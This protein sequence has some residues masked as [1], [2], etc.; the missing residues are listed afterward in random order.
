[1]TARTWRRAAGLVTT[2]LLFTPAI[3]AR[4]AAPPTVSTDPAT[5][6]VLAA[7]PHHPAKPA[8]TLI[9]TDWWLTGI[10]GDGASRDPVL[11]YTIDMIGWPVIDR[12][13]TTS[14][15]TLSAT[16]LDHR[17]SPISRGLSQERLAIALPRA[18]ADRARV[19]D[20]SLTLVSKTR[21]FSVT[22]PREE[23]GAFLDGYDS[24]AAG[25]PT[26]VAPPV[27]A[28][29][30]PVP[31]ATPVPEP[32]PVATVPAPS[33]ALPSPAVE[34]APRSSPPEPMPTPAA[35]PP[36]ADATPD[37][38]P[39]ASGHFVSAPSASADATP[40]IA[41]LGIQIAATSS[42]A[43]VLAVT[44]GSK[45]ATLGIAGGDFIEG[46]DGKSIKGLSTEAM[47]ARIGA[48]GVRS[49]DCIAAGTVKLR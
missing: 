18:L 11:M 7:G 39:P 17:A 21:S 14:G 24:A 4:Q 43:M 26:P 6:A 46:V 36:T 32:A 33:A 49:L 35:S 10:V 25:A 22:V 37:G 15:D 28:A 34:A 20:L 13:T 41:S 16:V 27:A 8:F 19:A 23:M 38:T 12:V 45:A 1:M 9:H 40:T 47:V 3:A 42:G 2:A 31:V 48:P 30:P 44:P 29:P 5:H